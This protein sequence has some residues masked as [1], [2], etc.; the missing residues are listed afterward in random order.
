MAHIIN[1]IRDISTIQAS[2]ILSKVHNDLVFAITKSDIFQSI[3]LHWGIE[4]KRLVV[5]LSNVNN[6]WISKKSERFV[7]LINILA[8]VERTIDTLNWCAS[9]FPSLIVGQCH[10]STS[11]DPDGNDIVLVDR[12]GVIRIRIE[13]CDVASNKAG[14]NG[15]ERSDL[16]N[17]GCDSLVPKD[18]VS[19]FIGTSE[20]FAAALSSSKRKWKIFTTL[21]K[22][23]QL[24]VLV[25]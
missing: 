10:P 14:Q 16:A 1:T 25:Q 11:H 6:P 22:P 9:Q 12:N 5:D 23:F 15:K 2:K 21:M 18:D 17:L 8:T 7:E 4:A 24:V 3:S 13:V 19:R 20:E